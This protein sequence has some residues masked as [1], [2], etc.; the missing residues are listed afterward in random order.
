V[1]WRVWFD[2]IR[3]DLWS[4]VEWNGGCWRVKVATFESATV[5]I[6]VPC[7]QENKNKTI[8]IKTK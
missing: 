1:E 5:R 6:I 4:G 7:T 3:Y 8:F 2:T